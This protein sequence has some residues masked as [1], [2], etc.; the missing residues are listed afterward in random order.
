M[1]ALG[2]TG[3][4]DE[5]RRFRASLFRVRCAPGWYAAAVLVPAAVA[6]AIGLGSGALTVPDTALHDG[7]STFAR[8]GVVT[9]FLGGGFG[10][11]PG[12][13]GYLHPRIAAARGFLVAVLVTGAIWSLWHVPMYLL[14][15]G[16]GIPLGP[17]VVMSMAGSVLL[18]WGYERTDGSVPVCALF[19]AAVN[20]AA[21]AL[22]A[23]A[24]VSLHTP[25]LWAYALAYAALAL[26]LL[27]S[28]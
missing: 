10:E 20:A 19:H 16:F 26:I 1:A 13:R 28:R 18:G 22:V 15:G 7:G 23:P 12:W 9:L 25:L 21:T 27:G 5:R 14:G 24:P 17:I 11:E 8:V 3:T 2:L 4:P 6:T